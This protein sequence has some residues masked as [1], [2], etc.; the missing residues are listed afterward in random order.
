M[1]KYDGTEY[2]VLDETTPWFE[3]LSYSECCKSLQ[4]I[5]HPSLSR[6]MRY[7]EY[8]KEIKVT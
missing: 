8:L 3:W 6:F 5:N 4:I 2:H 1:A 7:H